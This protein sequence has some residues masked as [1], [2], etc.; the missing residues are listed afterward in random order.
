[1]ASKETEPLNIASMVPIE[2]KKP[3]MLERHVE[4]YLIRRM[5]A[6][7]GECIKFGVD[8]TRGVP[9]RICIFPGGDVWFV[10]VKR[11]R[12]CKLTRLQE[13]FFEK[14]QKL[15]VKNAAVVHGQNGVDRWFKD[16]GYDA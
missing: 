4:K 6:L 16:I 5:L 9:D 12:S 15:Q 10:E 14:M 8:G 13:R 2:V 11:D 3:K 7:G 1:M